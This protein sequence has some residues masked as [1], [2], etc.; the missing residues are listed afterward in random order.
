VKRCL[1]CM[2]DKAT[3]QFSPSQIELDSAWCR[4]CMNTYYRNKNAERRKA[5]L[6]LNHNEPRI[7]GRSRCPRCEAVNRTNNLKK[8]YGITVEQY[9]AML[10]AQGGV[11][12]ICAQPPSTVHRK[13]ERDP[14]IRN[15]AVD[16]DHKTG[17]IRG[18]LCSNCNQ[19]LGK[20]EDRPERL[21]AMAA[22]LQPE[23]E[24]LGAGC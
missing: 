23:A 13:N 21:I 15:L 4:P 2:A 10:A 5:G 24:Y 12:R 19:A 20:A 11:C 7:D 17:R 16:H 18:L 14:R 3:D 9:D 1:K 22:Y 8:N 6:C